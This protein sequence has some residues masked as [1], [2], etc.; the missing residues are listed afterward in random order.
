MARAVL[1]KPCKTSCFILGRITCTIMPRSFQNLCK[2]H[3]RHLAYTWK[4]NLH[5]HAKIFQE[6][7][8]DPYKTSSDI[9]GRV[10]CS[11]MLRSFKN[12]CKIHA[13]HLAIFLKNVLLNHAKIFQESVQ[14]SCKT[15]YFILGR[16]LAQ[17]CQN[18][19]RSMHDVD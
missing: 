13:G 2:I 16:K 18:L 11:I 8:Q 3:A 5:N 14:D 19:S 9:L 4:N 7:L 15:S 1:D 12:L 6:S 10:S 17:S